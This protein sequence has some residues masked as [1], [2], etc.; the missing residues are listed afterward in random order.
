MGTTCG[1]NVR[2][3]MD[4]PLPAGGVISDT[5]GQMGSLASGQEP[6]L[7]GDMFSGAVPS[8]LTSILITWPGW[9]Q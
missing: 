3:T 4:T 7:G 9:G 8:S 1:P 5:V 2:V 6:H